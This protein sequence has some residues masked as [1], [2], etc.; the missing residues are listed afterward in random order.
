MSET[1]QAPAQGAQISEKDQQMLAA[2]AGVLG[3]KKQPAQQPQV[4]APAAGQPTGNQAP[5]PGASQQQQAAAPAP[6]EV[7]TAFGTQTY[8]GQGGPVLSSFEDVQAFAKE[9]GFEISQVDDIRQLF[10]QVTELKQKAE[11]ANHLQA[12]VD[13][14][15]TQLGSLPPPVLNL[16]EAAIA[17]Q[18]YK[19]LISDI[20]AGVQVDLSKSFNDHD[21]ISLI[22]QYADSGITKEAYDEL[23]DPNK[24]ALRAV[25]KTKYESDQQRWKQV[26]TDNSNK[27]TEFNQKFSKS[28]E[29]S[30]SELRKAFPDMDDSTIK[31]VT[32]KMAYGFKDSLFNPDNTYKPEAAVKIAMQ[33]YGQEALNAQ[34]NTIGSLAQQIAGKIEG[35]VNEQ[36]LQRSDTPEQ[37]GR[38]VVD[39]TNVV[40]ET[41]KAQTGFIK[42][43]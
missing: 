6:I 32:D 35:K 40:A 43:K 33:E 18:D 38:N 16:V 39:N 31:A 34:K 20:A 24:N 29:A 7:K 11:N 15:K 8:G 12:A 30:V 19:A 41:V 25:A 22:K 27:Q 28:I 37:Q 1:G 2:A 17:G 36:L 26:T 4:A 14:Y 13:S 42:A 3:Q 9:Q 21:P 10:T 23:S 5:E